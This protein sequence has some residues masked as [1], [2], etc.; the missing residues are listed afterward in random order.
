MQKQSGNC[1]YNMESDFLETRFDEESGELVFIRN[2]LTDE[3]VELRPISSFCIELE[4][5]T[6]DAG[7]CERKIIERS[8]NSQVVIYQGKDYEI[9][10][11][12]ALNPDPHF[13]QSRLI[14]RPLHDH[15]YLIRHI[16][17]RTFALPPNAGTLVPF[18]HGQCR[19]YFLRQKHGGFA[20]GVQVPVLEDEQGD[21]SEISLG[22]PVNYR[23]EAREVYEAEPLFWGVY[24]LTGRFAP[25]VPLKVKECVQSARPPDYGESEAMLEFA[26]SQMNI[27]PNLTTVVFNGYNCGLT[28]DPFDE[29]HMESI[30]SDRRILTAAKDMLGEFIAQPASTWCGAHHVIREM[31]SADRALPDL[32]VR[33]AQI[34]WI[35]ANGMRI[36]VWATLKGI[37]PWNSTP[38]CYLLS[39]CGDRP[40]WRGKHKDVDYNCPVN[41]PFMDWL[42]SVLIDDIRRH[43]FD[44]FCEDEWLPA[45]RYILP[46]E[47]EGHDH[48]PGDSS[49]GSFLARRKLFQQLRKEFPEIILNGERPQMDSGIW[50]MLYLDSIFTLSEMLSGTEIDELRRWSRIRHYYH[51]VPSSMDELALK[52]VDTESLDYLMLTALA[53]SRNYLFCAFPT[54]W[55]RL[56]LRRV[57]A[58]LDWARER[59]ELMQDSVFLPDWPGQGRCDGYVRAI[60]GNGY[61][62]FFN[63]NESAAEA[64][65]PLDE[66]SGLYSGADY[67]I[68]VE[69]ATKPCPA[70]GESQARSARGHIR[71]ELPSGVAALLKIEGK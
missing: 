6:L 61:A 17:L 7:G 42:T 56:T 12:H 53:V 28:F 15:P 1:F 8:H 29:D 54:G 14:L 52:L 46:C 27:R 35:R 26:K 48:L 10:V 51:F 25:A 16:D 49:Y 39:F 55:S 24:R 20:F 45:P 18:Q 64:L 33:E 41:R 13:L 2:K 70:L 19:T 37:L 23:F 9:E 34:E 59:P 43:G 11:I 36:G 32:P 38:E 63:A 21:L 4:S 40:D 47:A 50:D 22:Y 68:S 67:D 30:Q 71:F 31:K 44:Q 57:R 69:Y 65:L 5:E 3:S 62:F 58:W 60:D 66:S